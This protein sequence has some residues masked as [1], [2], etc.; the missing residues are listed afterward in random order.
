MAEP[1]EELKIIGGA[2]LL[3]VLLIAWLIRGGERPGD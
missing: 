1:K 2:I 3:L